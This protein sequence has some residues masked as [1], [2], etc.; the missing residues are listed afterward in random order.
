MRGERACKATYSGTEEEKLVAVGVLAISSSL[1]HAKYRERERERG[2]T[3]LDWNGLHLHLYR[4]K[5][6]VC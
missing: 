3:P 6:G 5:F 2:K 4:R 1:L